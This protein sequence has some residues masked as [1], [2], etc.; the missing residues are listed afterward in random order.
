[1]PSVGS[2]P[3]LTN[4]VQAGLL[5]WVKKLNLVLDCGE[6]RFLAISLAG[7]SNIYSSSLLSYLITSFSNQQLSHG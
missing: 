3:F 2:N 4:N 6:F 1:M 7:Y 5:S